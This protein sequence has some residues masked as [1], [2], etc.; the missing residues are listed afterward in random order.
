MNAIV[1]TAAGGPDV[2]QLR[3]VPDPHPAA[4]E[5]L[6]RV[7]AAGVNR[8]D[9][10]QRRGHYPPPAGA[11]ADIPGMEYAGEVAAL[12][13]GVRAW[14]VGDR[15]MGLVA[16]GAYAEAVA[17]NEAV[18]MRFPAAWSFEEAAAVPEVFITAYDALFR[19]MRLRAGERVLIHAVGSGVG[20]AALQ[21]ARSLG[22]RTFG[23]SRSAA[24]LERARALGLEVAID[25][26]REDFADV[27]K[28]R[29][30]GEGV[31]V[32]LDLVGGPVLA[33]SIQALARGGRMII[34]GLTGGRSA[35][36]DLGALLSKRLTLVGTVLRARTLEEKIGVTARF[37]AEV[38]PLLE[39]GIVRPVVERTFP[40]ARAAEAHTLLETDT[41]F[42]KL[43]LTCDQA[44]G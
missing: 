30:S 16:S 28:R 7:R 14:K 22:A 24:K 9:V 3:S 37:V 34:V 21:L 8:A 44:G 40:L 17:V 23:T 19:Q 26:S 41:V 20:T 18:A 4:G 5:V 25:T 42:G 29:T 2:L 35:P 6:V 10:L 33:G 11:P 43:V 13:A 15:V 36:I 39:G 32:I 27:I 1:I 38:L 31:E 12:G